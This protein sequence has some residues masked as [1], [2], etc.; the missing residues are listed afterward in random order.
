MIVKASSLPPC[1]SEGK[2]KYN[3]HGWRCFLNEQRR[4]AAMPSRSRTDDRDYL[5]VP[6]A[7]RQASS[8]R[9]GRPGAAS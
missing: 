9:L 5:C 8:F 7:F 3:Q 4:S 1:G 2:V 6:R